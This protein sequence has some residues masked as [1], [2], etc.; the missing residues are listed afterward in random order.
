MLRSGTL[1][2][3]LLAPTGLAS[4]PAPINESGMIHTDTSADDYWELQDINA[5]IL[6]IG[7]P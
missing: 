3:E 4:T 2:L 7:S 6:G 5:M 1:L